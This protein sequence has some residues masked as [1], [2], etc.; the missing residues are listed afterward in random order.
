MLRTKGRLLYTDENALGEDN[1]DGSVT[2]SWSSIGANFLV[3][4]PKNQNNHAQKSAEKIRDP[5]TDHFYG[6][7]TIPWQWNVLL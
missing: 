3:N 7:G 4:V 2:G 1:K 5:F 6:R